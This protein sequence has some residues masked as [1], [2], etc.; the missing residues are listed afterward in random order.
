MFDGKF[1]P[2]IAERAALN[3]PRVAVH[4]RPEGA[5]ETARQMAAFV[6]PVLFADDDPRVCTR[7]MLQALDE[8]AVDAV[9]RGQL[10]WSGFFGELAGAYGE[11]YVPPKEFMIVR[12]VAGHEFG[13]L[14]ASQYHW[15]SLDEGVE[16]VRLAVELL[17]S[18][19]PRH[20][21]R[22]AIMACDDRL[23]DR[24]RLP[25]PGGMVERYQESV[26]TA[27][28]LVAA[29]NDRVPNAV[30]FFGGYRYERAIEGEAADL[31]VPPD[32]VVGNAIFRS[33]FYLGGGDMIGLKVLGARPI[34]G[35]SS[36]SSRLEW[37]AR[38]VAGLTASSE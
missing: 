12:T 27:D 9:L 37:P 10:D 1:T 4:L 19:R 18:L 6:E 21:V 35:N 32:G 28:A 20:P 15:T 30:A 25:A 8:G 5:V 13:L 34:F 31:V 2:L 23:K 24:E 29:V 11:A 14:P 36:Y 33:L 16:W 26:A 17:Q 3:R 22:I 7:R 38:F